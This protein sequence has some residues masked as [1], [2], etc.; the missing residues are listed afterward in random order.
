MKQIWEN[1]NETVGL[2][3]VLRYSLCLSSFSLRLGNA[4]FDYLQIKISF[5]MYMDTAH[6]SFRLRNPAST[7]MI[8]GTEKNPKSFQSLQNWQS[9]TTNLTVS[10]SQLSGRTFAE[11]KG[12]LVCWDSLAICLLCRFF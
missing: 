7:Q 4:K 2:D 11:D 3:L 8:D 1:K 12:K 5:P 10:Y 9:G 6:L